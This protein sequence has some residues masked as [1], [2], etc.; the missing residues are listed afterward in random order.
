LTASTICTFQVYESVETTKEQ[1]NRLS[2]DTDSSERIT[3]FALERFCGNKHQPDQREKVFAK[4]LEYNVGRVRYDVPERAFQVI[5][6]SPLAYDRIEPIANLFR[7]HP[8][9]DTLADLH[10][11]VITGS[12]ELYIRYFGR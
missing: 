9:A 6:G 3:F 4:A 8:M 5:N 12:D 1:V 2:Y 7:M 10:Q 11:G